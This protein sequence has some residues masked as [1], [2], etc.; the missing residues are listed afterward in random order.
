MCKS[1]IEYDSDSD[2]DE[3][4]FHSTAQ[5]SSRQTQLNLSRN[6]QSKVALTININQGLLTIYTLVRDSSHNVIPGQQGELI[7]RLEDITIFLVNTYKGNPN[8]SYLCS[9]IKNT[10]LNHC[11]LITAPSQI[12]LLKP[13]NSTMPK[14]CQRVI[15]RCESGSNTVLN[16]S[17]KDMI[18]IAVRIQ[19]AHQ[20]HR[21]K[22]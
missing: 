4:I 18:M 3:G 1:G 22:V 6:G 10:A 8:L 19:A 12:P 9:M 15:Y 17:E 21:I 14:H 7:A 5:K 16:S 20:T 2:S 13:I 11:G